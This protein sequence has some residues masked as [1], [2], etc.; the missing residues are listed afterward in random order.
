[1]KTTAA[2]REKWKELHGSEQSAI[3]LLVD[4]IEEL[5]ENFYI[6]RG[7]R[8]KLIAAI[9]KVKRIVWDTERGSEEKFHDIEKVCTEA[10]D[11]IIMPKMTYQQELS[12]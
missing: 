7:Q 8:D 6:V 4:D 2:L 5:T 12:K 9:M 1:M 11:S 10:G 3:T